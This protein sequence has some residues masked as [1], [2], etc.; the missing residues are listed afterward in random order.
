MRHLLFATALAVLAVP[1]AAQEPPARGQHREGMGQ[2]MGQGMMG[3]GILRSVLTFAPDALLKHAEHLNLT[4]DQV[5]QLTAL[6]EESQ[7]VVQQAHEPARAAHMSLN[8]ALKE[9][10]DDTT[11]IRGYFKAHQ[12]AESNMQWLRASAAFRARALLTA[13][14]RK[15]IESMASEPG[16]HGH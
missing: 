13:D 15:M 12:E 16:K 1:A 7:K 11:A 5:S 9:T 2:G 6:K 3:G 4:S 8:Q 14:Q 10:P